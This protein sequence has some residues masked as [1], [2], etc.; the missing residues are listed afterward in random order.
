[1]NPKPEI[2]VIM[3]IYNCAKTLNEALD[4][5]LNQTYTNWKVI[6]C[7][8]ASID[9]TVSVAQQY[10]DKYPDKFLLLKNDINM[11][12]NYTLNNCLKYASGDY[13]ARMDGDDISVPERFEK[14][15]EFLLNNPEY[16]IVSTQM[17]YFDEDGAYGVSSMKQNPELRSFVHNTPFCHAPCMVVK[18]A[19]ETVGGYSVD[20]KLLRAEDYHL[21]I[22]MYVNGFKGYNL[23]DVLYK[24]RNDRNA[25][26]RRKFKFRLNEVYVKFLAVKLLK[27]PVYNIIYIFKPIITGIIP[28]WFYKIIHRNKLRK[29]M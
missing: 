11:G 10:V 3:G 26:S 18:N 27:L 21:W 22:K 14:E 5:I 19:Y 28:V 8:D 9:N 15:I 6:M 1:M 4:S 17:E 20:T 13:I 16:S 23:P 2:S 29:N 25:F 24:M 7:D 12:L